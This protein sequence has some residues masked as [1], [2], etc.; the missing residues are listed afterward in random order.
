MDI[1]L[2]ADQIKI[3]N[4]RLAALE[5]DKTYF[6][7]E[8]TEEHLRCSLDSKGLKTDDY[9]FQSWTFKFDGDYD[10]YTIGAM[11]VSI[12]EFIS[13]MPTGDNLKKHSLVRKLEEVKLMTEDLDIDIEIVNPFIAIMDKLA[14]N[15]ITHR[16]SA[17]IAA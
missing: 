5:Y 12:N 4:T 8:I 6:R 13:N 11:F 16:K 10:Y 15:A 1:N 7:T 2:I 17:E 3:I 9:Q 14:T